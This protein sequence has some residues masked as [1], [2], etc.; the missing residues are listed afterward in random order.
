M[1]MNVKV[2]LPAENVTFDG[3]REKNAVKNGNKNT[4]RIG[5]KELL[6]DENKR[7][8]DRKRFSLKITDGSNKITNPLCCRN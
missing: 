2:F 6:D 8:G 4:I 7:L 1:K 5:G 3:K